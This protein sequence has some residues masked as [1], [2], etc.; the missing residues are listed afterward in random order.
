MQIINNEYDNI[1]FFYEI[2]DFSVG[3]I[4]SSDSTGCEY[5]RTSSSR[6]PIIKVKKNGLWGLVSLEGKIIAQPI[7]DDIYMSVDEINYTK[8]FELL[9]DNVVVKEL[10]I[11]G[12][13]VD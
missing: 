11:E 4:S 7:Y 1:H 3:Q 10:D 13:V 5:Y 6:I 9:K 2:S 12:N 8:K